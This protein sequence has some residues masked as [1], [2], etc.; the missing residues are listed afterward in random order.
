MGTLREEQRLFM[1]S[2]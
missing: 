2:L 1:I